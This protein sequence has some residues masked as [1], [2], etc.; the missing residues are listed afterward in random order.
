MNTK[1]INAPRVI[2]DFIRAGSAVEQ[3]DR[4]KLHAD[5]GGELLLLF[6][7]TGEG[8]DPADAVGAVKM[9]T[10]LP[11]PVYDQFLSE[12]Q[13]M[14]VWHVLKEDID[15]ADAAGDSKIPETVADLTAGMRHAL[16]LGMIHDHRDILESM[17]MALEF[18]K[19]PEQIMARIRKQF[20]DEFKTLQ[21]HLI[22]L[23]IE[24]ELELMVVFNRQE[25][26]RE[27][28]EENADGD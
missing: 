13:L 16:H 23:S 2:Y 25:A 9:I 5:Y 28:Q 6:T 27:A 12:A 19:T 24:S 26:E 11:A 4:D 3:V 20:A 7:L 21:G 15:A 17:V 8:V 1:T 10:K 18:G 22:D 14:E